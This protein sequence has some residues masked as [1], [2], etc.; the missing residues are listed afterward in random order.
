MPVSERRD[1][2]DLAIQTVVESLHPFI[3]PVLRD[4]LHVEDGFV[5]V[6]DRPTKPSLL[7]LSTEQ[8]KKKMQGMEEISQDMSGEEMTDDG[9]GTD[10]GSLSISTR[11]SVSGMRMSSRMLLSSFAFM[12]SR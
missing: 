11:T 5:L 1:E 10:F 6:Q 9:E 2:A 8:K 7:S 4:I 12:N 3:P